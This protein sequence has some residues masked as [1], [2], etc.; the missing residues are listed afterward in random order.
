MSNPSTESQVDAKR[1]KTAAGGHRL[2]D[3]IYNERWI[4]NLRTK[5]VTN[6]KGCWLWQG[7]KHKRGYG[8]TSYRGRNDHVHRIVYRVMRGPVRKGLLVCH[9]C[10]VR[11]CCNPDHLWLGTPAENSLDMVKK[12][13]CHEWTRTHC[14]KGHPYDEQ[15][16]IPRV[17]KS[18]R[19]ARGCKAC[20][21]AS[22]KTPSYL[23]WRREY[24]RRRRS[25]KRNIT[26]LREVP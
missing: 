3:S 14:P 12:G 7:F 25:E 4:A 2:A 24:Q 18:G 6:E 1:L 23:A 10:D 9:T 13:R 16:T 20:L 17:A 8:G 5:C 21:D 19:P 22:H 15:N 26:A 11:H